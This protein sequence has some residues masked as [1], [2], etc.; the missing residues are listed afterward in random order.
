MPQLQAGYGRQAVRE[1][2]ERVVAEL[3]NA[4]I[5]RESKKVTDPCGSISA[6]GRAPPRD[7]IV[8]AATGFARTGEKELPDAGPE[9]SIPRSYRP[10]GPTGNP[11]GAAGGEPP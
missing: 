9:P 8:S 3:R 5:A 6:S 11:I 10:C 7:F 1:L 2:T 4:L